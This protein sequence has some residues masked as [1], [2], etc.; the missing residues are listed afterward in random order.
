MLEAIERFDVGMD[1][2]F[3]TYSWHWI[4]QRITRAAIDQGYLVRLPVHMFERVIK[5]A[6][7]RGKYPEATLTELAERMGADGQDATLEDVRFCAMLGELY[8]NTASLNALIGEDSDTE[9]QDVLP[10]DDTPPV[11]DVVMSA[12]LREVCERILKTLTPKEEKVMRLRFGFDGGRRHTLDEVGNIFQ[13]TRERIRQVEKKALGK[14]R[15]Q[16]AKDL[17]DFVT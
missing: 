12:E 4:R 14:L 16:R 9:L 11:E 7:Y 6:A 13:V 15:R 8:L 17:K 5:V 3:L 10:D 2:K 1:Y